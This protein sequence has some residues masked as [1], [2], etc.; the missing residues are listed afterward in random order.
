[1]GLSMTDSETTFWVQRSRMPLWSRQELERVPASLVEVLSP[2]PAIQA[3][4]HHLTSWYLLST[5]GL[6]LLP[7]D[8]L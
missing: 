1:M 3:R 5:R 7:N 8:V 6:I 2:T 4:A